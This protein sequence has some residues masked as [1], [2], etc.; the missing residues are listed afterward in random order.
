MIGYTGH[1]DNQIKPICAYLEQWRD[2]P[3]ETAATP[4][5]WEGANSDS[6]S[7]KIRGNNV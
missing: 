7:W 3:F 2:R 5:K 6:G 4:E 1:V